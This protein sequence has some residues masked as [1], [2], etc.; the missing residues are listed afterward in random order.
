MVK[1]EKSIMVYDIDGEHSVRNI[2]GR[3]NS[4]ISK[5]WTITAWIFI[6]LMILFTI[7]GLIYL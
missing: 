1:N 6:I 7:F 4:K 5:K 2:E 3:K